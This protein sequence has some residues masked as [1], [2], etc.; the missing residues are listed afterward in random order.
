MEGT[1]KGTVVIY[2]S[3]NPTGHRA[4][5]RHPQFENPDGTDP[6]RMCQ[7]RPLSFPF[8]ARCHVG[9]AAFEQMPQWGRSAAPPAA[10]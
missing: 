3:L 4:A 5:T 7:S 10:D 8:A 1:L 6:N 2:P 9:A